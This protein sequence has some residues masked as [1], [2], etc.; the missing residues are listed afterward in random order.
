MPRRVEELMVTADDPEPDF[1]DELVQLL[2]SAKARTRINHARLTRSTL[3]DSQ[4]HTAII[5]CAMR[6]HGDG[7]QH[8]ILAPWLKLLQF[9]AARPTLVEK[10]IEY[11][12]GR[13]GGG[14]ELWQQMPR[15]YL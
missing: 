15:G 5:A 7:P 11:V 12:R 2:S 9:V 10:L 14:L 13:R 6:A 8:R 3:Y 1:I 4:Y